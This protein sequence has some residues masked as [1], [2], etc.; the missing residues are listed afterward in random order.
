MLTA[1]GM[2]SLIIWHPKGTGFGIVGLG[3]RGPLGFRLRCASDVD[4]VGREHSWPVITSA[5]YSI[6][7]KS[8]VLCSADCS[9]TGESINMW[10]REKVFPFQFRGL[11]IWRYKDI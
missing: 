4:V 7:K 5:T 6:W 11:N 8:Y 1:V 2:S 9:Q 10:E 3:T